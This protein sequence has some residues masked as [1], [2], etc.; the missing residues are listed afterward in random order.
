[1][2][3]SIRQI[4]FSALMILFSVDYCA[5][6]G[7]LP[8]EPVFDSAPENYEL[9]W[10]DDIHVTAYDGVD[11]YANIFVPVK[12]SADERFPV[13]ILPNS[14]L[15]E[16][17]EY[18]SQGAR[19]CRKGYIVVAYSAR[20]WGLSGGLVNVGGSDDMEDI[21]SIIDWIIGNY[22]VQGVVTDNS[23]HVTDDSGAAI[24]MCGISLGAGLSILGAAH[25]TRVKAVMAMVPW[26]D[27]VSS[28]YFNQTTKTV[29]HQLVLLEAGEVTGH[30]S[31]EI[32]EISEQLFTHDHPAYF[33]DIVD[34]AMQRSPVSYLDDL[35]TVKGEQRDLAICLSSS[36]QDEMF[37]PNQILRF[38]YSLTTPKKRLDINQGIHMSAETLGLLGKEDC[39]WQRAH[40]WL[41]EHLKFVE[42]GI[43][44]LP[45]M[46]IDSKDSNERNYTDHIYIKDINIDHIEGI[47]DVSVNT[48]NLTPDIFFIGHRPWYSTYGSLA[49][50]KQTTGRTNTI[51]SGS[52][53]L[54]TTGIPVLSSFLEAHTLNLHVK[55]WFPITN[56]KKSIVYKSEKFKKNRMIMGTPHLKLNI[57]PS[58]SSFEIVAHLYVLD[59][60]NMGTL[61]SHAPLTVLSNSILMPNATAGEK[62]TIEFNLITT[63][64]TVGKGQRLA[65]AIDTEDLNYGSAPDTD[66]N[67]TFSYDEHSYLSIPFMD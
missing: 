12:R 8:E 48:D 25:D 32:R 11:I 20:G 10:R 13:I 43:M 51:K 44:D 33:E 63:C 56:K 17:H 45:K 16:E 52:A 7:V 58:T 50:A 21:S 14:W 46:S 27:L 38:F 54:I 42:T 18:Y 62:I 64:V 41:D 2:T 57:T 47:Y 31:P 67:L 28:L 29:W 19:F 4:V 60:N 26:A 37:P 5:G 61:I 40:A 30:L 36:L 55:T 49:S 1:M 59:D 34:W 66:F 3:R 65:L 53:S 39:V 24:G 35:N 6:M 15:F 23:G 9:T 22:P